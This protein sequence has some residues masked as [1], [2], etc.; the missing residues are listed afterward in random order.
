MKIL[1]KVTYKGTNYQG[2][3]KQTNA[4][5]VQETIESALSK[6]LNT[7]TTIQGSGRTDTGVHAKGQ[8]FHF[9]VNKEIYLSRLRYSLNCV[10]PE[11]I[12]IVELKEVDGVFHARHS[13][14]GKHYSYSIKIGESD[15]FVNDMVFVHHEEI[16]IELFKEALQL[17]VGT[18]NYQDFTS[19]EEDEKLFVREI[20]SIEVSQ[21]DSIIKV[22]LIGNGFMRYMIRF[23]IGASLAVA[24]HREDIGFIKKHLD[25]ETRNI[26]NYKAPST[27]LVLEEVIY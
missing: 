25:S 18:H 8:T 5:S 23:I 19:K 17:F 9:E 11:D 26:I 16:D 21:K 6:I 13:A 12:H 24:E 20:K 22:D 15:P 2:W 27:G 3:Q 10:L 14:K 7:P 1:A 4:P